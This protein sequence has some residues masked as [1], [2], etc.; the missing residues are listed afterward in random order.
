MN[1]LKRKD[2]SKKLADKLKLPVELIDDVVSF[3][4][5]HVQNEL[6]NLTHFNI[7]VPYLGTFYIK[8]KNLIKKL[9]KYKG[10]IIRLEAHIQNEK[11]VSMR[12]YASVV[13]MKNQVVKYENL[14]QLIE[15]EEEKKKGKKQ[16]KLDYETESNKNLEREGKDS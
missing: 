2:V 4:Y 9:D 11:F 14:L 3:Y 13:D 7:N 10:A 5:K 16:E 6:S 1:P 8:K 12:K 15:Q